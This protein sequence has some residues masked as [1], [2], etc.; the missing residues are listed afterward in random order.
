MAFPVQI[1]RI[2]LKYLGQQR[3]EGRHTNVPAL[4]V[5]IACKPDEPEKAGYLRSKL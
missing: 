3:G 5:E 4:A 1:F 2:G